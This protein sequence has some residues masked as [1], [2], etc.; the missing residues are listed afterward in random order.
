MKKFVVGLMVALMCVHFGTLDVYA[1]ELPLYLLNQISH[2][3]HD[4][5]VAVTKD[6]TVG[7]IY[8]GDSR[9]VGMNKAVDI[10]QEDNQFVV[11]KVGQGY[12]WLQ[13][14]AID[15]IDEIISNNDFDRWVLITGLGV[16]DLRNID[17]YIDYYD[18]VDNMQVVLVSVNPVEKSG[19][20]KYGYDYSGLSNGMVKFNDKLQDTGYPY[21]DTYDYMIENGF[22]TRDG[23]HYTNDTYEEIYGFIREYITNLEAELAGRK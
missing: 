16:N 12:K 19:C 15:E 21:I 7:Y 20:D 2:T 13:D 8:L 17:K 1:S 3:V 6:D 5:A 18:S 22:S 4:A 10:E 23:V 11:A 9:F 14:T